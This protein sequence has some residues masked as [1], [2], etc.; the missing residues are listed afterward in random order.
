MAHSFAIMSSSALIARW[1]SFLTM[2]SYS[3]FTTESISAKRLR[4]SSL[5][6]SE[7]LRS[8]LSSSFS[9]M[10]GLIA[11]SALSLTSAFAI[12]SWM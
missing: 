12:L 4:C 11:P 1:T 3:C 7:W 5:L 9:T 6:I 8:P 10:N 2:S